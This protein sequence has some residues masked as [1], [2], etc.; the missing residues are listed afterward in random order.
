MMAVAW[1]HHNYKLGVSDFKCK[2]CCPDSN[3][4][5]SY[6]SFTQWEARGATRLEDMKPGFFKPNIY[7]IIPNWSDS[8]QF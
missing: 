5:L 3:Y 6:T 4:T 8:S 7:P 1:L 2:D